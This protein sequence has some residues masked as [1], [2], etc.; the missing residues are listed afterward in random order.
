[1]VNQEPSFMNTK[2]LVAICWKRP[3]RYSAHQEE[4]QTELSASWSMSCWVMQPESTIAGKPW[5][6]LLINRLRPA[7][8]NQNYANY[9]LICIC[10]DRSELHDSHQSE[11]YNLETSFTW[12]WPKWELCLEKFSFERWLCLCFDWAHFW[13]LSKAVTAWFT[14]CSL[15][16]CLFWIP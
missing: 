2:S 1:M 15:L 16:Q 9:T 5:F 8:S 10:T 3:L 6:C 11:L 7:L 14:N 12:N 4:S 13:F